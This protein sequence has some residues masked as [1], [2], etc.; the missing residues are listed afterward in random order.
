[1]ASPLGMLLPSRWQEQWRA[2]QRRIAALEKAQQESNMFL[3]LLLADAVHSADCDVG[4]HSQT[5]RRA[6]VRELFDKLKLQVAIETGT[7]IGRTA[8]YL[9]RTFGM[10]VY[11]SELVPRHFHTARRMLRELDNVHLALED[12]RSFLRRLSSDA[13]FTSQRAFI[14]LDAHWYNDLPLADEID[15][16]AAH[17]PQFAILVDD[18]QVPG[19]DGYAFDDYGPGKALNLDYLRPVL[20]RNDLTAFFPTTPSSKESGGRAGYVVVVSKATA[21]FIASSTLLK[22]HVEA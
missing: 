1:M 14:Y 20:K 10:P 8:N 6:V 2:T 4:M 9:A 16:I 7:F 12:S 18:F 19:D 5:Q 21:A 15:I 11:S 17:W 22:Q 13:E 3:D